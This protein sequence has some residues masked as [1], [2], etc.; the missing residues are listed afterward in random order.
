MLLT[1]LLALAVG[2]WAEPS[3][4]TNGSAP[5]AHRAGGVGVI[6]EPRLHPQL[7][8]VIRNFAARLPADWRLHLVHG[9][10]NA[11]L[12]DT[13]AAELGDRLALTNL[14]VPDLAP[15]D[16]AYNQLLASPGFW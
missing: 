10:R 5:F 6:V 3:F 8:H 9:S 14:G 1:L 16:T 13:L 4:P 12:A 11:G 2:G 15:K 7:L